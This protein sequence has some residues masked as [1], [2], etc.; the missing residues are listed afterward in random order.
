MGLNGCIRCEYGCPHAT[1]DVSGEIT[2]KA[3]KKPIDNIRVT[4]KDTTGI[5]LLPNAF[6]EKDGRYN[7]LYDDGFPQNVI[8]IVAEDTTGVYEAD[9]VQVNVKFDKKGV[10]KND[11]WNEGTTTVQQ[12]FHLKKK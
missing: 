3:D 11:N 8:R 2:D 5:Q 9:S 4:V 6:T 7:V 1:Y 10:S 12:D